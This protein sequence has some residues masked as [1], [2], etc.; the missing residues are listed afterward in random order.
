MEEQK[1]EEKEKEGKNRDPRRQSRTLRGPLGGLLE[2]GH[3]GCD[4]DAARSKG[5]LQNFA[6]L[7]QAGPAEEG[8]AGRR[9]DSGGRGRRGEGRGQRRGRGGSYRAGQRERRP[10]HVAAGAA[11]PAAEQRRG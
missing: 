7:G 2:P 3:P 6:E 9:R 8:G 5:L 11:V 1:G 10:R 4:A